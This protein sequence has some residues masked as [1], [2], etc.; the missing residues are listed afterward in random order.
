MVTSDM[1]VLESPASKLA[2]AVYKKAVKKEFT[3]LKKTQ[4]FDDLLAKSIVFQDKQCYL[5]PV[6]EL[7]TTDEQLISQLAQWRID[8]SALYPSQSQITIEGTKQWLRNSLLNVEDRILFLVL[9]PYGNRIGHLGF[10]NGINEKYELE[11]DNVVRGIQGSHPGIMSNAVKALFDWAKDTLGCRSFYLRTFSDNHKAIAFYKKLGFKEDKLIPLRRHE[12]GESVYYRDFDGL[13][14]AE[15]DKYF[16]R[17]VYA[18][19]IIIDGSNIIL[20]AGSSMSA[21][22]VSYVVDA[23]RYGWNH[24]FKDYINKFENSFAEYLGVKYALNTSHCTHAMHLALATLEIG[25]GDEVIVP[26]ITWV[27]TADAVLYVGATP[28]FADVELDS[29]CLDPVSFESKITDKTK[30]VMPVHLY[31]HP[32]RMDKIMEIARR[33]NLYVVEDAAPAIGAECQGQKVGTFGDFA[34]YSFQGAKLLVTGE[35]GMLVTNNEELYKKAWAL[36]NMGTLPGTFWATQKGYKY[37][38]SNIQAALGLGQLERVDELI[39]AKRRIFSWY[40]EGL[41]DVPHVK[42]NYETNWAR[43]IYWMSS[44]F[45]EE[46]AG[47]TRDQLREELKKRNVDTRPV[48]PAISQYPF[49]NKPQTP[50]PTA[51]RVGNQA[52]NLPSGVCLKREEVDYICQCL[53]EI[54]GQG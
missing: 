9:D 30:A 35:G 16:L 32:A 44:I 46:T 20:T 36:W 53:Q 15:P 49:W 50:Q 12:E 45:L 7:H 40:D 23:V 33:H 38:M 22:E 41:K 39:E 3:F 17:M 2:I 8:N 37:R 51:L 19:K 48:F 42:L 34:A 1:N 4:N 54:L 13:D 26:D 52:I 14:Q 10:A 43:S 28:I 18:P 31:G 21:R 24:K 11:L 5:V 6:C 25:P 29:W 27:A 47:V